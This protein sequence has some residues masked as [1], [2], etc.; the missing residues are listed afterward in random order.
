MLNRFGMKCA[1]FRTPLSTPFGET[2]STSVIQAAS[3]LEARLHNRLG[4]Q[5][6]NV[7]VLE[8]DHGIVLQGVVYSYYAKQLAQ[9]VA[10]E[11]TGLP[12][13]ANEIEVA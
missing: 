9:H 12:V 13:L 7:E 3:R 11:L 8:R 6:R 10:M 2:M 1:H 5:F 4:G